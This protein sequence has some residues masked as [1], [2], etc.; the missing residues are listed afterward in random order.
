MASGLDIIDGQK[1]EERD[2]CNNC[3]LLTSLAGPSAG[4][5][6][7]RYSCLFFDN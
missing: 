1:K 6:M 5:R 2:F 4:G 3:G 7:C